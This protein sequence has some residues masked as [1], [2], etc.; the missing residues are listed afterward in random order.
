MARS[1]RNITG[2]GQKARLR[3]HNTGAHTMLVGRA[4]SEN[5][6]TINAT[7]DLSTSRKM[8]APSTWMKFW[9]YL[10]GSGD[11]DSRN[12]YHSI[13][14]ILQGKPYRRLSNHAPR[15]FCQRV[16]AFQNRVKERH[17][18]K[19]EEKQY[20]LAL[21]KRLQ[22]LKGAFLG[23]VH[24]SKEGEGKWAWLV[25]SSTRQ[26]PSKSHIT[27]TTKLGMLHYQH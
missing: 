27:N 5:A 21:Q 10:P 17:K 22:D 23:R 8:F 9:Q 24:S 14:N 18:L 12:R 13:T 1:W 16:N 25:P 4:T 20:W 7:A 3:L 11:V 19:L 6:T 2:S 15:N 26:S